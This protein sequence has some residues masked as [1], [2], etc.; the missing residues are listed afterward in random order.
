MAPRRKARRSKAAPPKAKRKRALR[1]KLP[2][3]RRVAVPVEAVGPILERHRTRAPRVSDAP[4][5]KRAYRTRQALVSGGA[6]PDS[7]RVFRIP[8]AGGSYARYT[9]TTFARFQ[10]EE[11]YAAA[12]EDVNADSAWVVGFVDAETGHVDSAA[13][14]YRIDTPIEAPRRA[15]RKSRCGAWLNRKGTKRC[16][17][18]HGHRGPHKRL[19]GVR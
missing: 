6:E 8:R 11:R 9:V 15:E 19:K 7:I 17:R 12:R 5:V 14:V 3:K 2:T 13:P 1:I 4:M 18:V 16:N 10:R